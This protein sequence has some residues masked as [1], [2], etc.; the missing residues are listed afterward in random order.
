MEHLTFELVL[1]TLLSFFIGCVVGCLLRASLTRRRPASDDG[2][3]DAAA[4]SP[5]ADEAASTDVT[6]LPETPVVVAED[7]CAEWRRPGS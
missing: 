4:S 5:V 6:A 1:W 2:T 3:I 7:W